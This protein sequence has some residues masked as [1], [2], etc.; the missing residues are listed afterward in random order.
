MPLWYPVQFVGLGAEALGVARRASIIHQSYADPL[1]GQF[2][3]V[4]SNPPY[5]SRAEVETLSPDVR[6]HDPAMALSPGDDALEAY[7]TILA[8]MPGWL[9]PGDRLFSPQRRHQ[10]CTGRGALRA[11]RHGGRSCAWPGRPALP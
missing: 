10:Q 4:L 7:R 6:N 5:I 2:D 8:A 1:D 3:L 11:G 9:K